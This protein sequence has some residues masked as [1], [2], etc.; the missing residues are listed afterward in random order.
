MTTP[1]TVRRMAGEYAV[2]RMPPDAAVP[3]WILDPAQAGSLTS[4]T[5]TAGELSIVITEEAIPSE[6]ENDEC[7]V[8]RGW[9]GLILDG[10]LDF[11]EIGILARLTTA[12]A[13][14]GISVFALSTYDTDILLVKADRY[15]DAVAVL[16]A[17]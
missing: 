10:P 1:M 4:I 11:S 17:V 2:V 3:H 7:L 5:R 14:A 9:R 6:S 13:N 15:D 8:E 12:L 16:G